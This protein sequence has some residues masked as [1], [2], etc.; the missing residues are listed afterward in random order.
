MNCKDIRIFVHYKGELTPVLLQRDLNQIQLIEK[1]L[2][3]FNLVDN[4]NNYECSLDVKL[5][6]KQ[7]V[8]KNSNFLLDNDVLYL[9]LKKQSRGTREKSST[10]EKEIFEIT[11]EKE[12]QKEVM[13]EDLYKGDEI[14]SNEVLSEHADF[15]ERESPDSL[16]EVNSETPGTFSDDNSTN[17]EEDLGA[18]EVKVEITSI[19]NDTFKDRDELREKLISWAASEKMDLNFRTQERINVDGTKISKLQCSKNE[20]LNCPFYLKYKFQPQEKTYKLEKYWDIHNHELNIFHSSEAITQE[21]LDKIIFLKNSCKDYGELTK[22][23]NKQFKLNFHRK[24]IYYQIMKLKT[25]ENGTLS[26]DSSKLIELLKEDSNRRNSHFDVQFENQIFKGFSFMT[27]RMISVVKHFYDVL[28]ID[29]THGTNR[30]NLPLLDIAA[31]NNFGK[32]ITCFIGLLPDQKYESFV[33]ALQNFKNQVNLCPTVIF[34]DE[35]EALRKGNLVF[36]YI[37][38]SMI[39]INKVFPRTTNFICSWHVQQNLKK[40]FAFLNR[41][42]ENH[43]KILYSSIISL[44]YQNYKENFLDLYKQIS[45]SEHINDDLKTYLRK[46]YD[47]RK[48]WVKA[49]MKDIFCGGICTTSRIESKHKIFKKYLNSS[50]R[51]C[52]L[53]K[54][55]RDLEKSEIQTFQNEIE[56]RF[57]KKGEKMKD[58]DLIKSLKES[59]SDYIVTRL[60]DNLF[61]ALNYKTEKKNQNSW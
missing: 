60:K 42:Q 19:I 39:A 22:L 13:I 31:I 49:F 21:I 48:F 30:F 4:P 7:C 18:K 6:T 51:L 36:S 8:I 61:Q 35:E 50:A 46:R 34:S 11:Y 38:M 24:T 56:K 47:N 15:E 20:K 17:C 23:I 16:E 54:V 9:V 10:S 5:Q 59:Y 29:T 37:L 3:E 45:T 12:V 40:K 52:E 44:P 53:F 14:L 2:E 25:K 33:W 32:T 26:E 43:K 55:F 28:I 41:S 58:N 1:C 27:Q 57:T